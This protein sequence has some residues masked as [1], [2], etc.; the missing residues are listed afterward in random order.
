ME[1]FLPTLLFKLRGLDSYPGGTLTHWYMP[2][3]AGRTHFGTYSRCELSEG[4]YAAVHLYETATTRPGGFGPNEA[5][6][7]LRE[8]ILMRNLE[9]LRASRP[10]IQSVQM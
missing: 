4:A 7:T 5:L 1:S 8:S 2:A 10:F 6:C 9:R 3:F